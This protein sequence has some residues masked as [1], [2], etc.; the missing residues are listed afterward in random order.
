MATSPLSL[1][2]EL[3]YDIASHLD[4]ASLLSLAQ[5]CRILNAVAVQYLHRTV[6]R[7]SGPDTIRC[8]NTFA[9]TPDIAGKV[10]T[11]NIY[12]SFSYEGSITP[13]PLAHVQPSRKNLWDKLLAIFRSSL[14]PLRPAA[15][16]SLHF[17]AKPERIS[18]Q[19]IADAFY[20]LKNLHTLIIYPPSH[21]RIWE[22]EHPIPTLRT[23]FVHRNAESPSLFAWI[24]RQQSITFLRMSFPHKWLQI[25][26]TT[27]HHS[28]ITPP[29]S[30]P[31]LRSLICNP[32]GV[33]DRLPG[34]CVSEL[35]IEELFETHDTTVMEY[36]AM[37]IA[38]SVES[39]TKLQRLTVYGVRGAI[40]HLLERL[41]HLLPNL[42]FLRIFVNYPVV[43]SISGFPWIKEGYM[44]TS[45]HSSYRNV[46]SWTNSYQS[47]LISRLLSFLKSGPLLGI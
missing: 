36:L 17:I 40:I 5:S 42:P 10:G 12:S 15:P 43:S 24:L 4:R 26:P 44:L 9:T 28:T 47:L 31:N 22:F 35:I 41:G 19:T 32:Q 3:L 6:P 34:G 27:R 1:P 21:P 23:V 45:I 38:S 2:F 46:F 29:P 16:P 18:L 25:P 13:L 20:N 8:L 30:L 7:L 11:F 14:P 33:L 37:A 39:G